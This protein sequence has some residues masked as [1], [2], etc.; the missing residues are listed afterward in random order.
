MYSIVCL[1]GI[2]GTAH[3]GYSRARVFWRKTKS[4]KRRRTEGF[5]E[6]YD[7]KS[8][9]ARVSRVGLGRGIVAHLGHHEIRHKRILCALVFLLRFRHN[10]LEAAICA[11]TGQVLGI[12]GYSIKVVVL[13]HRVS[14]VWR[15]KVEGGVGVEAA[16]DRGRQLH[17]LLVA[18]S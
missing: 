18:A 12:A 4:V 8:V 9:C 5:D 14:V 13:L 10:A 7:L 17:L 2:G 1:S 6:V 11:G 16:G 15:V 3:W